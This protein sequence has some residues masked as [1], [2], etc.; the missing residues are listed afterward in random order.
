MKVCHFGNNAHEITSP[1][2]SRI[3]NTQNKCILA[4]CTALTLAISGCSTISGQS[5]PAKQPTLTVAQQQPEKSQP[6][7]R[8]IN[9]PLQ[10][11]A[12]VLV[13]AKFSDAHKQLRVFEG[14]PTFI[15]T[16]AKIDWTNVR[17]QTEPARFPTETI[18]A[19]YREV[20]EQVKVLRRRIE[21]IG[22]PAIYKTVSKPVT[23]Q[24]AHIRWKDGCVP[25]EN[26][27]QCLE[28]IPTQYKLLRQQVVDIPA[29][30]VQIEIP[31]KV[32]EFKRKIL[33]T[34]G[35]GHG[36]PVP[37][38]YKTIRVGKVTEP[39]RLQAERQPTRYED[40]PIK[41]KQR[42]ESIREMPVLC[43]K[44]ADKKHIK[45]IQQ[46]LYNNGYIVAMNGLPDQQT[47]A[48][49]IQFQQEN[50]LP[51]GAITLQ[52]LRKLGL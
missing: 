23:V 35:Q 52:T 6:S 1:Q 10:C 40:V 3:L 39:W 26:T 24:K 41:I 27:R 29:R 9:I 5:A 46:H 34:P 42:Q 14:S 19:Q 18:P 48:A 21:V 28:H 25:T 51:V 47:L 20:T 37:A 2:T 50:E 45:A 44:Q 15:N 17:F 11:R 36:T 4:L 31:E 16:P 49:V 7:V 13:P 30:T 33:V 38:K 22:K 32:V 12:N 43:Y 8:K